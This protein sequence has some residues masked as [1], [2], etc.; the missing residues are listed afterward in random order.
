MNIRFGTV[1]LSQARINPESI[2]PTQLE[3]LVSGD[4]QQKLAPHFP[5]ADA[6]KLRQLGIAQSGSAPWKVTL[7]ICPDNHILMIPGH[8]D[9]WAPTE[10]DLFQT[11]GIEHQGEI[12]HFP[13]DLMNEAYGLLDVLPSLS[14]QHP[15][16]QAIDKALNIT[17]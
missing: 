10:P 11:K 2:A 6:S 15:I 12:H 9:L 14:H 13:V 4:D 7:G 17:A 5:N 3:I 16:Q 1:T 8:P